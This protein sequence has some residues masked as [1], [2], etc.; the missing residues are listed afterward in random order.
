[1]L[2]YLSWLLLPQ[3]TNQAKPIKTKINDPHKITKNISTTNIATGI[4]T[5]SS[6]TTITTTT[7]TTTTCTAVAT[8]LITTYITTIASNDTFSTSSSS[9]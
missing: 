6:T 5:V 8:P 9:I 7:S 4:S 1:M 2:I 3:E